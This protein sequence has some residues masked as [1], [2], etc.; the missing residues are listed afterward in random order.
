M[1]LL[2][3]IFCLLFMCGLAL[4]QSWLL[5]YSDTEV[6]NGDGSV[7]ITPTVL[8]WG[9]DGGS[10]SELDGQAGYDTPAVVLNGNA[11]VEGDTVLAGGAEGGGGLVQVANT[12]P[13][14]T[15]PAGGTA[16]LSFAG[17]VQ[18]ACGTQST[19]WGSWPLGWSAFFS[20][21]FF[22]GFLPN[23][24]PAPCFLG[25]SCAVPFPNLYSGTPQHVVSR[26]IASQQV[27]QEF[28]WV[29]PTS[30]TTAIAGTV[31]SEIIT[32]FNQTISNLHGDSFDGR[33]VAE[34]GGEG[35]NACYW[36]DNDVGMG[37]NPRVSGGEWTV[38][39]DDVEGQHNHWGYDLVGWPNPELPSYVRTNGPPNG[40]TIP[41]TMWV[42]QTMV[43]YLDADTT[44]AYFS[45]GP[46]IT[47]NSN[48]TV[49]N[50][51]GNPAVC[52][53]V[54]TP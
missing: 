18:Q 7:T 8:L 24:P 50:C 27:A 51:R 52:Q 11:W 38:G 19:I 22:D 35:A 3:L 20:S 45:D 42:P 32:E 49:T 46:T 5:Y 14:V 1:T 17:K 13:N 25:T 28:I 48:S 41:C 6:A 15:L 26:D 47:I 9:D 10:C 39:G 12:F 40:V 44:Y 37:S 43:I 21:S 23:I 4:G 2:G 31:P 34:Q 30:E 33:I 36:D 16:D 54:N 53:T 29:V